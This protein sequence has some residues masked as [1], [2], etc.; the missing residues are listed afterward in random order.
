[1]G[2]GSGAVFVG[3]DDL[4]AGGVEVCE[5]EDGGRGGGWGVGCGEA[6]E[7]VAGG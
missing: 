5:A 1:M 4:Q 6:A 3:G 7:E 2:E